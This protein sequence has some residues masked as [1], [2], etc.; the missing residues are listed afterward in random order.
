MPVIAGTQRPDVIDVIAVDLE[1]HPDW[2]VWRVVPGK[3]IGTWSGER[4]SVVLNLVAALPE[5]EAM[6]CFVP[7]YAIRLRGGPLVLTE[8]AFC[9]QCHNAMSVPI[10]DTTQPPTWF[11]FDPDSKPAQDLLHLLRSCA[12]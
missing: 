2:S 4:V 8:V 9:F 3:V 11:T 5:S 6:R 12:E 1:G 10:A 7:R